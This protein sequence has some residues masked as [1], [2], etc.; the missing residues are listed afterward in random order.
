MREPRKLLFNVN[1]GWF[2]ISHRLEI[3]RAARDNGF[4][5]H[6]SGDIDS[7]EEARLLEREGF[8]F[9]RMR[10][11]RGG[12]SLT[13]DLSYLWRL[14]SLMQSINPLIVHNVTVKPV[15]YGTLAARGLGISRIVNAVSGLGYAF[16]GGESRRLLAQFVKTAYRTALK[17]PHIRVI[18]QNTDDIE[19]FLTAN[20]IDRRQA[21]LIRGSGVDLNAF[22]CEPEPPGT[23]VV[24]LPARMLRDKGVVEFANAAKRLRSTGTVAEFVLAGMTDRAN[25][26]SLGDADLEILVRDTGVKWL[27]HVPDMPALYRRS[28]IVCLP[29]YREGMP[30]SLL[31]ACAAGRPIVATDVPG[32]REAVRHGENGILV[33]PRNVDALAH[34]LAQVIGDSSLRARMGAA[35]RQRAEAEFDVRAVVRAT[36]D[37]YQG[38]LT[39]GCPAYS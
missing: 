16:T 34:G 12:L 17:R 13:H 38:M 30:K 25:P 22:K 39:H 5:V 11:T 27:G 8:R 10:L 28:H 19:T 33:A 3:A 9:H 2:F 35:G 20:I 29:S 24:V 14:R 21:F 6:V 26:A 4:E 23:P 32:C 1:V 7:P 15:I 18:F 36:L 37:V 31:E